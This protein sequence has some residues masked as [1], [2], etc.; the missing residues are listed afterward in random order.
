MD[1]RRVSARIFWTGLL[2]G[3]MG[4][5]GGKG[6]AA[7]W[8][9]ASATMG[10]SIP[11]GQSVNEL[12]FIGWRFEV[13]ETLAVTD[14]GGHLLGNS[15]EIFAAIVPLESI[16]AFPATDAFES[17]DTFAAV[18]GP[19]PAPSADVLYPLSAV[20]T[21]GSYALVF[22]T[23]YYDTTENGIVVNSTLQ[24]H[25][26]PTTAE[27]FI[28]GR[29]SEATNPF[30]WQVGPAANMRFVVQGI[31]PAGTTD[32]DVDG[33]VDTDDVVVWLENFGTDGDATISTG[34]ADGDGDTDGRD[35]LAWQRQRG[36]GLPLAADFNGDDSVDHAD[37]TQWQGD[38]GQTGDSDADGDGD[39][40]GGDF[41]AWQRQYGGSSALPAVDTIPEPSTLV[42]ISMAMAWVGAMRRR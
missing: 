38:F 33:D 20:L 40:D 13:D 37:L 36:G 7:T 25:I 26:E 10:P 32:F 22:G 31:R 21:P 24:E 35:L 29:R 39:S 16:D 14:V 41:L 5:A 15:T 6:S 19:L 1:G 9:L 27:S 2:I 3:V 28:F 8:S 30:A 4:L 23:G 17:E 11:G 18:I 12:Q 34:D 42:L